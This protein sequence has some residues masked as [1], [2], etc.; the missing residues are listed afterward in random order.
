GATFPECVPLLTDT[1]KIRSLTDPLKKMSKSLGE[2]NLISLADEPEAIRDKIKRAITETT[3][4]IKMS[5]E[6]LERQLAKT[7]LATATLDELRGI[8]G[9][10]NLLTMLKLF[11]KSGEADRVLAGQ[12]IKYSELKNL[13]ATRV[14]EHFAPFRAK[15]KVLAKNPAKVRA[16]LAAGAKN[17]RAA[18][19]ATMQIVRKKIGL[20]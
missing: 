20:R 12:P 9:V 10:W 3:G 17:A 19:K 13:V 15:R 16:V 8:S 11:G 18:A 4:V 2:R 7:D 14:A 6:D 1:P 5:E